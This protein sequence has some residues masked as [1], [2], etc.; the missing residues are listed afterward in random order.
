MIILAVGKRAPQT[1]R[2]FWSKESYYSNRSCFTWRRI[3]TDAKINIYS[4]INTIEIFNVIFILIKLYFPN[5]VYWIAPTKY[6]VTSTKT[7]KYS[8][9]KSSK[10]FTQRHEF[11]L[12]LMILRLGIFN[13]ELADRFC[14]SPALFSWTFTTW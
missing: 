3:K 7:N 14:I 4:G 2:L 8:V 10:T 1:L 11:L 12:T 6:R 9:T 5:V 13:E